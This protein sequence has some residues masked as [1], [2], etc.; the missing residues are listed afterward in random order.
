M[1]ASY[2]KRQTR[3]QTQIE[4]LVLY[5]VV[6]LIVVISLYILWQTKILNPVTWKRGYVGFSQVVP[7]DWVMA[8]NDDTISYLSVKN[9]GESP[10]RL[11]FQTIDLTVGRIKCN[12][13]PV[14]PTPLTMQPGETRVLKMSCPGLGTEYKLGEYYEADIKVLYLNVDTGRD[15]TSVGKLYGYMEMVPA[16]YVPPTVTSTTAT[17]IPQCF[18]HECSPLSAGSFDD[19]N[20]GE[21]KYL[22]K[23]GLCRYCPK[24]PDSSG[25]YN[26]EYEG[27]CNHACNNDPDCR[28]PS[29]PDLNPCK[30]C[31]LTTHKCDENPNQNDSK[32]N[33]QCLPSES[34]TIGSPHCDSELIPNGCPYC[35][36]EFTAL[37]DGSSLDTYTCKNKK[38]CGK[39]C[40][41]L[42]FDDYDECSELCTHCKN[43]TQ[44]GD[45]L[46]KGACDQGDCGRQCGYPG[47]KECNLGCAWCNSTTHACEMGDCGKTCGAGGEVTDC[48]LGCTACQSVGV[49]NI[50]VHQEIGVTLLAHNGT[51]DP[52]V[53]S[54]GKVVKSN[55]DIYLNVT[56]VC[57]ENVREM[58]ISNS[59]KIPVEKIDKP[60]EYCASIS[61]ERNLMG[62]IT[63]PTGSPDSATQEWL[64]TWG[65]TWWDKYTCNNPGDDPK[66]CH[67][68][69][70][71]TESDLGAYCYFAIAQ[72]DKTGEWSQIASDYIQVGDL[73]VYLILPRPQ[74]KGPPWP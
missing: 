7:T 74:E 49:K 23:I 36:H 70:M 2:Q 30:F 10:I 43:V 64:D 27:R 1:M 13:G 3:G 40:T 11:D 37:A 68:V 19:R 18:Y 38:D 32:C 53:S 67:H 4:N 44:P 57:Q 62:D 54:G 6:L 48:T 56:A 9:E 46:E 39:T 34:G 28:D 41:N 14:D 47:D 17:T 59:I 61:D 15:H 12:K 60:A 22:G 65:I 24:H 35:Y 55:G 66:K 63:N 29:N 69:W 20:C 58:H 33:N 50:C 42:V 31:N 71:T 52:S 51:F 8:K 72:D 5:S 25:N 26:C 45:P 16:G 21:I 73:E